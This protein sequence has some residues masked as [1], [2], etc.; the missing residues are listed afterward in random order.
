MSDTTTL[1]PATTFTPANPTETALVELQQIADTACIAAI[2]QLPTVI[3]TYRIASGV[4]Q[5]RDRIKLDG[6]IMGTLASLQDTKL[7][8]VT[9]RA[10]GNKS[11]LKPYSKEQVREAAIE[12]LLRGAY[13]VDNEFNIIAGSCY[14]TLNYFRR[15]ISGLVQNLEIRFGTYEERLVKRGDQAITE[16][17]VSARATWSYKGNQMEIICEKTGADDYRIPV[18]VNASMGTDAIFGKAERKLLA[19]INRKVTGSTWLEKQT[20]DDDVIDV[21]AVDP[22]Q[23]KPAAKTSEPQLAS[24]E[25]MRDFHTK[26]CE[27]QMLS[28]LDAFTAGLAQLA[29][30]ADDLAR[31]KKWIDKRRQVIRD[32]RGQ[33]ANGKA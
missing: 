32:G 6:E 28:D 14:L 21:E 12:A 19:R 4:K 16:A 29:M 5:L 15:I 8:F 7:G 13:W 33:R 23:E 3:R 17:V 25:V 18:R 20:S 30:H 22:K 10:P 11:G 24:D 1:V 31:I 2:E 27:I 26:V 9:D